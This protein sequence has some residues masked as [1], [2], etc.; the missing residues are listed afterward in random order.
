MKQSMSPHDAALRQPVPRAVPCRLAPV[1]VACILLLFAVASGADVG[2]GYYRFPDIHDDTVVFTAEGD[3][4]TVPAAGGTARRLTT[5]HG[6]E[7]DA[8]VAPDGTT[9]A[10]TAQYE[11]NTEVYTMPLAGGLPRR[12]TYGAVRCRVIGW[13]PDGRLLYK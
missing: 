5:H 13:T 8:S 1:G 10:F 7:A 9:V 4:W 6:V 3:L 11:G 2:S 12:W